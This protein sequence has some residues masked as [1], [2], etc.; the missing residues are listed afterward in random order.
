MFASQINKN[1]KL[2]QIKFTALLLGLSLTAADAAVTGAS[3]TLAEEQRLQG[4]YSAYCGVDADYVHAGEAAVERWQ[5]LKWGLRIHWG[6]YCMFGNSGGDASWVIKS[7][8]QDKEW[9]KN[10]Y[11]SY[12]KFNPTNFNADEWMEIM[13]RAG[14]K[15]FS[16]TTKH[17]EGFCMWPTKTLQRGFRKNADG[18]FTEVT[19]HF[20]IA[21]TPFQRDIVSE[22]VQA[23]R[24][25]HL[26]VSLYYSH[27]DWHDWDFG[28]DNQWVRNFWHDGT[29]TKK[30]D[31]PRR[32]AAFI[33][34][35]RD[36]ITELL[37]QYGLI[38]TLC[39]D[40]HWG[41]EAQPDAYGV[42]KLARSL[43]PNIMLRN[44][45]IDQYGDYET[46]EQ[47]IPDDPNKV[48]RPWQVIYQCGGG[49]SY[50]EHGEFK[51]REWILQSLIDIVAKGGN[52]QAGYGPGPDGRFQ[53][54]M[55]DNVNYVGD[56]L[57]VNGEAIFATRPYLRYHEGSDLRFTRTK[58]KKCTYIISLKW[59]G[60]TLKTS[61]VK[62]RD[63]SAIRM[64][65]LDQDLKW[66]R[67]G[68]AAVI[69]MPKEMQNETKRPCKQAYAF[70]VESEPW[71]N[72]S[73]TLP[74]DAS[75]K[76]KKQP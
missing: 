33:Q 17:H 52:F 24:A 76:P 7:H 29:F 63:G 55:I 41:K 27:I 73:K 22:L 69:E 13:Q 32:W 46:P 15:Y 56:W 61:L 51:S 60:E 47:K 50:H 74:D 43:Q 49:F 14:M 10:Y 31:D 11:A 42:A 5:D 20:S 23:G 45:G 64:L 53:Q 59:P 62:P 8:A 48:K 21:E 9:L 70:K 34:K 26:G 36:Q 6:L 28:W 25:H 30:S 12:Q 44:R 58:D 54:E 3:I 1:L 57:K 38:D 37:T 4:K 2:N 66:H 67:E 16:F 19:N 40:M 68:D 65:G 71:G 75:L 72:F 39:L 35:E 18:T